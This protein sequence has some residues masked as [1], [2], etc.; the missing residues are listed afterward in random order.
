M[1]RTPLHEPVNC[2]L[3]ADGSGQVNDY[4]Y[5]AYLADPARSA[6]PHD[7]PNLASHHVRTEASDHKDPIRIGGIGN[8]DRRTRR[9][10]GELGHLVPQALRRHQ[11]FPNRAA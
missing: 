7:Q 11:S 10:P 9:P 1:L 2:T 3:S 5:L 8:S 6:L 4:A